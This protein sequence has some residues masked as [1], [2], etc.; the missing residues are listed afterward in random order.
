MPNDQSPI[1]PSSLSMSLGVNAIVLCDCG[2]SYFKIG[3]AVN[4]ENGN[5]FI[6]ILECV[7]CKKHM[8]AT[9]ESDTAI[10]PRVGFRQ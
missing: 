3:V 5:N 10:T 1:K 8:L 4:P 2:C 6:R 7:E 9:H